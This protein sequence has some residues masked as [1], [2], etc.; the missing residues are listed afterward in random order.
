[1]DGRSPAPPRVLMSES[2]AMLRDQVRGLTLQRFYPH[3]GANLYWYQNQQILD[4]VRAYVDIRK[5]HIDVFDQVGVKGGS[6]LRE[7]EPFFLLLA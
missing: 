1:M 6:L 5:T 3:N 2:E 4:T 7:N